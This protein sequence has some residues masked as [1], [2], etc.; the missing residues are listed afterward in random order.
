ML[1]CWSPSGDGQASRG[2]LLHDRL[3]GCW[4]DHRSA[5][6][7][8]MAMLVAR[9]ATTTGPVSTDR[10][11][12]RVPSSRFGDIERQ[13]SPRGLWP[14][15]LYTARRLTPVQIPPISSAWMRDGRRYRSPVPRACYSL[16]AP[17]T[18]VV[19][20]AQLASRSWAMSVDLSRVVTDRPWAL[21]EKPG[22]LHEAVPHRAAVAPPN[23]EGEGRI[24]SPS[25]AAG[26]RR[27]PVTMRSCQST[28]VPQVRLVTVPVMAL[29]WSDARKTAVLAT[30]AR[31]GNRFNSVRSVA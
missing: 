1:R 15:R 2:D 26:C 6:T 14:A 8:R 10:E 3:R 28:I 23:K 11:G 25:A 9:A 31:V 5:A 12:L 16:V 21:F 19:L 7:W 18:K 4:R 27:T 29:A 20:C 30:S 17:S 13:G 22:P 24:A